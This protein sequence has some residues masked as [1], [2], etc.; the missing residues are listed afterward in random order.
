MRFSK[1]ENMYRVSRI[2]GSQ[3]NILGI[4][5]SENKKETIDLIEWEIK[6]GANIKATS[7]QV[8]EQ[9]LSGLKKAN[10]ELGKNYQ[11]SEIHFLPSDSASN[12][13]YEFL[14]QELVKHYDTGSEFLE[15]AS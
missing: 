5:F 12:S 11:L 4:V 14:I 3:D 13:V 7:E 2:T 8:L 15:I 1:T 9:V 10:E 6:E